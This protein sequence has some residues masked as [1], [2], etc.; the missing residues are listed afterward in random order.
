MSGTA[1]LA[2]G[3]V[4]LAVAMVI[5]YSAGAPLGEVLAVGGA[6]VLGF[7]GVLLTGKR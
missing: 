1:V 4:L 7:V 2:T 5:A 6:Y 3:G